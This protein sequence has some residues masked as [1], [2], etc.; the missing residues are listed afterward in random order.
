MKQESNAEHIRAMSDEE[1]RDFLCR[2]VFSCGDCRWQGVDGCGL[3]EWLQKPVERY[4]NAE[5]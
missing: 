2:A 5:K 4:D 1:L 3:A